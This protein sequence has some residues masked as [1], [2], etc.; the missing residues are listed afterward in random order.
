MPT[1]VLP[2]LTVFDKA[3]GPSGSQTRLHGLISGVDNGLYKLSSLID[4]GE[5]IGGDREMC[6]YASHVSDAKHM[7]IMHT[8]PAPRPSGFG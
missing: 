3:T 7:C 2:Y 1:H 8:T 5:L 4:Q 6:L